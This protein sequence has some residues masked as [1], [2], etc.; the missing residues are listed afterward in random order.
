[1]GRDV[2]C[3]GWATLQVLK[4]YVTKYSLTEVMSAYCS[5]YAQN[6]VGG[7]CDRFGEC[8]EFSSKPCVY[9]YNHSHQNSQ[10][11]FQ[12]GQYSYIAALILIV[13]TLFVVLYCWFWQKSKS[14]YLAE[15]SKQKP[16]EFTKPH[17]IA[18]TFARAKEINPMV[19][20]ELYGGSEKW[21]IGMEMG[22]IPINK[23]VVASTLPSEAV[24]TDQQ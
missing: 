16:F 1:M 2:W 18:K 15:E 3:W 8:S 4:Y 23:E 10:T 7:C 11:I 13:V 20:R 22:G 17:E 6:C 9:F 12:I 21:E 24:N 5:V 19:E 14:S